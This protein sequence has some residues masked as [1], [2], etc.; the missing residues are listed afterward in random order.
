MLASLLFVQFQNE[1]TG[2]KE[3][4]RGLSASQIPHTVFGIRSAFI[5]CPGYIFSFPRFGIS[6]LGQAS[7][8]LEQ[9]IFG[10]FEF[11]CSSSM[12][13]WGK[14]T[15]K[16][17][18][19]QNGTRCKIRVSLIRGQPAIPKILQRINDILPPEGKKSTALGDVRPSRGKKKY[20][21][22]GCSSL[23]RDSVDEPLEDVRDS[24]L[25][26]CGEPGA[27]GVSD[28]GEASDGARGP[29]PERESVANFDYI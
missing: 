17:K 13:F 15:K 22:G 14:V 21:S 29:Y 24:R 19:E 20:R 1:L 26:A 25:A 27:S 9:Q 3:D 23:Q 10:E 5:C 28:D 2:E 11:S 8:Y 18:L 6:K 7:F 12:R 16:L 4:F